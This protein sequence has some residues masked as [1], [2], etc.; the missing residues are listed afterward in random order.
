MLIIDN[1]KLSPGDII[2]RKKLV[3]T[4]NTSN[5][6]GITPSKENKLIFIFSDP[7]IGEKFGYN[8]GWKDGVFL[9]SGR[10]PKGSSG[11]L[12]KI[13]KPVFAE[14]IRFVSV[15]AFINGTSP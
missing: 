6:G 8:D 15:D 9:Y 5:Q 10:G 13:E 12:V 2:S 14:L 4:Y 11:K 3:D 7:N 1:K